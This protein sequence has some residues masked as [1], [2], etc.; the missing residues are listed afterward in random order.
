MTRKNFI[1]PSRLGDLI[2][3]S[4]E[5]GFLGLAHRLA[6][7]FEVWPEAVGLRVACY[8]RPES[9]QG[10]RLTVLVESSVWIDRLSYNREEIIAGINERLG[11]PV[12][13][14]IVFRV[15]PVS[16]PPR[17]NPAPTES[18]AGGP[19]TGRLPDPTRIQEAVA[20]V[21][22]T[23]LKRALARLLTRQVQPRRD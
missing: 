9:I 2:A 20:D 19:E 11:E 7:V 22:D 12:V 18:A 16:E 23:G 15:G 8:T 5:I 3:S 21:Q 17:E 14:E 13:E 10:G 6:R 1:G 4:Q